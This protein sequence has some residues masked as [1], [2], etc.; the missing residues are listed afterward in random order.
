MIFG[1]LSGRST[2]FS[3][4]L[5]YDV[6]TLSGGSFSD[7]PMRVL[8]VWD[9]FRDWA[10]RATLTGGRAFAE[11]D[12]GAPAPRPGQIFAIGLNYRDHAAEAGLP[13]PGDLTVFTKFSSS[14]TGP[15]TEV[16]LSGSSVDWEAELVVVLGRTAR[17]VSAEEAWSYVAGLTVGQDLSDRV[18]QT[19]GPVPQ[20]SLGKSFAGYSPV[21]PWLVTPDEVA[22][23]DDLA[24]E[25]RVS[26][27]VVQSGRTGDMVFGVAEA[28]A[29]L[30]RIVT[31]EPGD[32]IFTGTPAGVGMSAQPPRF[33]RDGDTLETTIHGIG[34]LRQSF[35]AADEPVEVA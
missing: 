19:A 16:T 17:R 23:P 30:S 4:A 26:G 9:D 6:A 14:L 31:L 24:I 22:D 35:A 13:L 1:N 12:L 21:G 7:D 15:V 32:L 28:I 2:L 33:L 3:D 34:S 11:A 8:A 20:F 27:V 25:T 18:V 5:A 29:R 10:S